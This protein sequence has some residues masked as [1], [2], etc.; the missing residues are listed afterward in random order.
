MSLS[1]T[2][3]YVNVFWGFYFHDRKVLVV[4]I[5]HR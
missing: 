5:Q 1:F 2:I 4:G 3:S